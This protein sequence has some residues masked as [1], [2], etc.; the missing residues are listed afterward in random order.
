MFQQ[1]FYQSSYSSHAKYF[2]IID[3]THCWKSK[4]K[5]R[6]HEIFQLKVSLRSCT[7]GWS[8]FSNF[9]SNLSVIRLHNPSFNKKKNKINHKI[10]IKIYANQKIK[11]EENR[12]IY[13]V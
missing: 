8:L 12:W 5:E 11:Y 6:L 4:I 13:N 2:L 1:C 10:E 3:N 9:Q 7:V